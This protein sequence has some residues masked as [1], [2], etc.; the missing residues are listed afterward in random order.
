MTV[1][2]RPHR[3][4]TRPRIGRRATRRETIVEPGLLSQSVQG[5]VPQ[6]RERAAGG[7]QDLAAYCCSCG[8]VFEAAVSTTVGC[9]N[10]GDTQA[11]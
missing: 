1:R 6:A 8:Y 5:P 2:T 4:R 9:P 10:C 11:W 3:L 7:P